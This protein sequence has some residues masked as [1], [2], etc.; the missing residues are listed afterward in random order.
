[1]SKQRKQQKYPGFVFFLLPM[2][3]FSVFHTAH[4]QKPTQ[5][6]NWYKVEL[7][8][9]EH[10]GKPDEQGQHVV[11]LTPPKNA[12]HLNSYLDHSLDTASPYWSS[13]PADDAFKENTQ[14]I[15]KRPDQ[16]HL[17]FQSAW[18]QSD[19]QK[20]PFIIETGENLTPIA[21]A[22]KEIIVLKGPLWQLE[23]SL[24]IKKKRTFNTHI[25]FAFRLLNTKDQLVEYDINEYRSLK[26]NQIHY[27]DNPA[28][29]LLMRISKADPPAENISTTN[30]PI[31][32]PENTLN[33]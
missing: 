19:A 33:S 16:Y 18:R 4:A 22:K 20:R 7:L 29:G 30:S 1:M 14:H 5:E 28:F 10:K 12:I 25:H 21:I 8:V 27:F 23:G 32:Q 6:N 11:P 15:A 24:R 26:F 17:L 9:F 3:L 13:L 2:A 31:Q